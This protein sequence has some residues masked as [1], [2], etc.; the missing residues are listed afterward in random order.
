MLSHLLLA[1]LISFQATVPPSPVSTQPSALVVC[2]D[3]GHPSEVGSGCT[4][5]DGATEIRVVWE[6]AKKLRSLLEEKRI[7]VIM[8]KE[9]E[10]QLVRNRERAEI[11]NGAD[12]RLMVRLHC[13]SGSSSGFALYYPDRQGTT[14][15]VTG[16]TRSVITRSHEAACT[17]WRGMADSL[18]GLLKDGGVRGDSKTLI[19]SRQG[20]LTGSIFS[21]VPVVTIEMVVL[22]NPKDAR[23]A[24]SEEGQDSLAKAIAAGVSKY[25]LSP[26]CQERKPRRK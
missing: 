25:V 21:N 10:N 24:T 2:I 12:A 15:G 8:T 23:F 3:P 4:G 22:S 6:V 1:T 18:A 11:A 17:L 20:A 7:T 13:D 19:G 26:A 9:K 16:P 14:Q 5:P